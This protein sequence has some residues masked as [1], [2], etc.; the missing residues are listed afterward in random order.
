MTIARAANRYVRGWSVAEPGELRDLAVEVAARAAEHA[1]RRFDGPIG[2]RTKSS[3]SDFVTEVDGECE[4]LIVDG[5]LAARPDDG[6]LGEEGSDRSGRSGVSW[7]VDPIDGTTNYVYGHAG[8]AVSVAAAVDGTVVA[9]AVVDP[10]HGDTFAA[11]SGRGATRNGAPIAPTDTAELGS[12]LI[13]TGFGYQPA[14]RAAQAD[15][16]RHVLP[17]VGNLRRMGA[18]S[19][20]LCWVACGRVDGY[21]EDGLNPW[22]FAAG[23]LVASEAGATVTGL[24]EDA[25]S[26]SYVVAATPA[27]H[28]RLVA[29]LVESG[30]GPV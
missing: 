15:R 25:P 10:T 17:R 9:G 27:L 29:L 14:Q 1:H 23:A 21:Y 20:D 28:A 18:A 24:L 19:T 8:W 26:P 3:R 4:R 11:A 7:L 22:D 2:V 6:V 30:A 16:L 12:A 13:A 5:I